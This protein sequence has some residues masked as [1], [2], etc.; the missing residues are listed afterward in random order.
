VLISGPAGTGKTLLAIEK[1]TRLAAQGL[2]VKF[3]CFNTML[4]A[5]LRAQYLELDVETGSQLA[6]RLAQKIDSNFS[7]IRELKYFTSS[8]S[9][10]I[11]EEKYDAVVIDEAQDLLS[12]TYL[13]WINAV[14]EGGIKNGIWY[15]FGDLNSQNIYNDGDPLKSLNKLDANFVSIKLQKNCRNLP[16]IGQLTSTILPNFPKWNG[17]RR[18]DDG[19]DPVIKYT[20]TEP[21]SDAW[22]DDAIDEFKSDKFALSDIVVLTPSKVL[23][24]K[25]L[26]RKSKYANRFAEY[27]VGDLG[28]VRFSTIHSFK[29][30]ESPC[31]L[32]L[33]L[34]ELEAMPGN[35]SLLYIA[36]TRATARLHIIADKDSQKILEDVN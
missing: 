7:D 14:V 19:I 29:G 3:L 20:Q 11:S 15:A 36:L 1:A 33:Q 18:I 4:A 35:D 30:L 5:T 31:I 23:D 26:F 6:F 24:P 28:S 2:T 8:H 27:Q 13:P 34:Y 10:P 21:W 25:Q 16:M 22:I 17:F 32:L 9:A 12:D